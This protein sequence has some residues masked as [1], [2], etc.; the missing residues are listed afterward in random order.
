MIDGRQTGPL[1]LDE[2]AEAGVRPDTYVWCK[3]MDDWRRAR[4][5]A[6]ICRY[7][8]NRIH[9]MMH[10]SPA[11]A[12]PGS[13]AAD[14]NAGPDT[15]AVPMR[16]RPQIERADPADVDLGSFNNQADL[17]REPSTWYPFPMLLA[18]VTFLPLGLLAISQARKAKRAWSEGRAADAHE[19]ARRGK[20][21]TGMSLSFGLIIIAA[22]IPMLIR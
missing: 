10:P 14:R 17:N 7:F 16:F 18:L 20:M 22:F 12:A 15:S 9:D 11:P 4:E 21:A 1:R 19:Y 13:E 2:L 8:R 5:V 6:D 3:D